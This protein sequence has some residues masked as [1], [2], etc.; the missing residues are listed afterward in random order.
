MPNH[1]GWRSLIQGPGDSS[2]VLPPGGRPIACL[3]HLSDLHL[4]D[5]ESPARMTHLDR[6]ADPDSPVRSALGDIGTYRP[7]EILTAHVASAMIATANG[8][9]HGPLSQFPISAALITG[10]LT[11]NAQRNELDWYDTLINGG[12]F[13]P[14]S[15]GEHST[16]CGVSDPA[17]W[18]EH[19]WH[20]EGPPPGFAPD[21]PTRLY[22][23]PRIPG[24]LKAS[25]APL[26][27]HG[28]RYRT[29]SVHGNHDA[30]V[31]GTVVP[32]AQ[33]RNLALSSRLSFAADTHTPIAS[34]SSAIAPIGPAQYPLPLKIPA[35]RKHGD[36]ARRIV[37]A[38]EFAR[39][40]GRQHN[41]WVE[42]V[43][44]LRIISLD[45]V[46]PFGG[47]QGSIDVE[48]WNW[49]KRILAESNSHY[50]VIASHHPSPS[51]TNDYAP[52]G[53][54]R[55]LGDAL[56]RL[57]LDYPQVLI[58]IA[59]HVHM[60]AA[61]RHGDDGRWLWEVTTS[62]LIDWPQQGRILE[63]LDYGDRVAI[64]STVVDHASPVLWE[65]SMAL[66]TSALASLSRLLAAN[67][68]QR[69]DEQDREAWNASS[70]NTRNTVWWAQRI[71]P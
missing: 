47:W 24:L 32:D 64:A 14:C 27:S 36:P 35:D 22:G 51:M 26:T 42:D 6:Y 43:D 2:G 59:G 49:L 60:N 70:A 16:W 69:R 31:Q 19:Y 48:Q 15:G 11:D 10:D 58:W 62:S 8:S 46:N 63:F 38:D 52:D 1:L 66:D 7:Q 3:W 9:S 21:R 40:F 61:I 67:D 37:N 30:L 45:T 29:L 50:V 55:I 53:S 34:V 23:Y 39:T 71:D 18:D 25:R 17:T 54:L 12:T 4:C 57:L 20:P 56:V 5:A 68:Y 44:E 13:T 65:P 28:L 41:Y 33:I